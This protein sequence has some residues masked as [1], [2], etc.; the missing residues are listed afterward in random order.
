MNSGIH[1]Q[2]PAPR[3]SLHTAFAPHGDGTHGV[4]I[5]GGGAKKIT[6]FSILQAFSNIIILPWTT[7]H[8]WKALPTYPAKQTQLGV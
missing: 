8:L 1:V 4:D 2:E 7:S 6:N 3:C 5:S